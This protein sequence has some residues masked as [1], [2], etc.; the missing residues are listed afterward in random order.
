MFPNKLFLAILVFLSL[1]ATASAATCPSIEQFGITW[2]F[3]KAYECGQF[4]NGDNWVLGPVTITGI[5]PLS[6]NVNGR[7]KNGSMVNPS[8]ANDNQGYDN[9]ATSITYDA[10]LN[11][12]FNVS[13]ANPL[14]LAAGSSLVST[15]SIDA[16]AQRP[17]LK[18]AAILTVLSSAPPAGSFRPPYSGTDKTIKF[19][20]SNLDYTKLAKLAPTAH[21]L[22]LK[23]Q[24]G[25]A[26]SASVERM[27]ERPWIDHKG[28]WTGAYLHPSDNMPN[29]GRDLADQ[30]GTAAL[31]LH[32][33]YSDADKET[34]MIRF[35]QLGIDLYGIVANG[36]QNNWENDGGH[37]Q[38]RKWPILFAGIVLNDASMKAI[39]TS[40]AK[41][42]EE[43]QTFYV[44]Q[45]DIDMKG[46]HDIQGAPQQDYIQAD[47]GL[48]EW[49]I[50]HSTAPI[51]D[52]RDW[53]SDTKSGY[54]RCCT[55]NSFL[56][57][58][59]AAHIMNAKAL[60][61]YDA[62]FDYQ[63]RY[64]S[65]EASVGD[66]GN[67]NRSWSKFP[68]E[69]WDTYRTQY[70]CVWTRSDP[71]DIYSNGSNP[72]TSGPSCAGTDANCGSYPNCAACGTS[73][74]CCGN[75]CASVC[76]ATSG[77]GTGQTCSNPGTCSA[78]CQ[79]I[80]CPEGQITIACY[81]QGAARTSGY[82]CGN[83]FQTIS[84]GSCVP[85]A[86]QS[87]TTGLPGICSAG[88]KA[89]QANN[90]WPATCTQ[91]N[92]PAAENCSNGLD[93][94]CD[95]V[96][97]CGDSDCF[98]L[99]SCQSSYPSGYVSWWKFN[100]NSND[101]T[102]NN[103]GTLS[104][105]AQFVADSIKGQVLSLDGSSG[106]VS[107]GSQ[108]SLDNL[109]NLTVS[110]WVNIKGRPKN[111]L[112]RIFVKEAVTGSDTKGV[113]FQFTPVY[114]YNNAVFEAYVPYSTTNAFAVS[115]NI[116]P[117]YTN[118][119][120]HVAM[121]FDASTKNITLYIN[122]NEANYQSRIAASGTRDNDSSGNA[123]IGDNAYNSR[124]F[125]GYIDDVVVY[126]RVLTPM[127]IQSIY[128]NT[129]AQCTESQLMN[130]ISQWKTGN[131]TIAVLMQKISAWKA[132]QVC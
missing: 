107:L 119:W 1:A 54:R 76:T 42:G 92:Q 120:Y 22:R 57:Y 23:Q 58:I 99:P 53:L 34:L 72:C 69:M 122:G 114:T 124:T 40:T 74:K 63:D 121:A 61:N 59:L 26:Q 9:T 46:H 84:C 29:Y 103:N 37:A 101:E 128:N 70:G 51:G 78:S 94:D 98:S 66:T 52:D 123:F 111:G 104:G 97:D 130:Y 50:M 13:S 129:G 80:Q 31:M 83:I 62:L 85:G 118:N 10:T 3:D 6:T 30:V 17:Q 35:V 93:D 100:G 7:I 116:Y 49:G 25:D 68:E 81:C 115:Q 8:P 19:N 132:A 2:T 15:I 110:A 108:N 56:G 38:G 21:T 64:M 73:Q 45:A 28:N 65:V 88:T 79:N 87:C 18:T 117:N 95:G 127:E 44:S 20:K 82:C 105:N 91:T 12:A 39:G 126:N 106:A 71:N 131:I 4:A 24:V 90:T 43:R 86:T 32:L 60:W 75:S 41:F 27:F 102:G 89:C 77:C 47:I 48:P 67:Y 55:G 125:N 112:G 96:A 11:K 33:N 16:A 109:D 113:I 5:S 14:V 36:G